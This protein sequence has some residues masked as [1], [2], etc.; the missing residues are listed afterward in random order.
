MDEE[1]K[2]ARQAWI[3]SVQR[4]NW[5]KVN[6]CGVMGFNERWRKSVTKISAGDILFFYVAG[7]KEIAGIYE[8]T[9]PM[10]EDTTPLWDDAVYP[11][12]I[13]IRPLPIE[14]KKE[15][16]S[17]ITVS[18]PLI[19]R[20][21]FIT[22]KEFWTLH[23]KSNVPRLLSP[24]D[25]ATLYEALSRG[26]IYEEAYRREDELQEYLEKIDFLERE[27]ARLTAEAMQAELQPTKEVKPN[28]F[29][30]IVEFSTHG[31]EWK[32]FEQAVQD[33]FVFLGFD[34]KPF[35]GPKETDLFVRCDT[36]SAIVDAKSRSRGSISSINLTRLKEHREQYNAKFILVV[37]PGFDAGVI[38]DAEKERM[39]LLSAKALANLVQNDAIYFYPD[40]L[41]PIFECSGLA[42]GVVEKL[43]SMLT[44]QIMIR[45]KIF[46]EIGKL[47]QLGLAEAQIIPFAWNLG[48]DPDDCKNILIELASP[49]LGMLVKRGNMYYAPAMD[50]ASFEN[51]LRGRRNFFR[52][53]LR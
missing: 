8:V 42:D 43:I 15:A 24:D 11:L 41:Q 20:L 44:K 40:E 27:V 22:N 28:L 33:A 10:Y 34:V 29:S 7:D 37:G 23:F 21:N 3:V 2:S 51:M 35:G 5:A 31:S 49:C 36:Y 13:K 45:A 52:G 32:E 53:Y 16:I 50:Q 26:E 30:R 47:Q 1:T 4:H 14:I 48:I 12:R 25:A 18:R 19:D 39:A 38:K 17:K 6:Q 9:S 46:K